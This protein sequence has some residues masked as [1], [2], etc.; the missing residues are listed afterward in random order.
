MQRSR[1]RQELGLS[2]QNSGLIT[3]LLLQASGFSASG[4][5]A[6]ARMER[7]NPST[8]PYRPHLLISEASPCQE[9]PPRFPTLAL[10][11]KKMY[12]PQGLCSNCFRFSGPLALGLE[13]N[14]ECVAWGSGS[15]KPDEREQ[16]SFPKKGA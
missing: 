1:G 9:Y 2:L 8:A 5:L 15:G 6:W 3:S 12:Q 11:L 4:S 13:G 14:W 10:N 16:S 7:G